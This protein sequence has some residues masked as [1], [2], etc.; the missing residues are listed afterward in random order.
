MRI[1]SFSYYDLPA[2]L[3]TCLLYLC[4]FPEDSV[5]KKDLLVWKWVAEGFV[6]KKAGMRLFEI[7]EGY[8]ND[9]INR[10]M[11]QAIASDYD[12]SIIIGCR[13]HD[14]VLDFIRSMSREE[15]FFTI[16][17]N[18][19]DTVL[20]TN[21]RRLAI[22]NSDQHNEIEMS[23]LRSFIALRCGFDT[24]N[25]LS[26]FTLIRVLALENCRTMDG[27]YVRVDHLGRLVQLRFLSLRLTKVG[28]LPKEIGALKL[29]QTLDLWGSEISELPPSGSLPVQLACLS[30]TLDG[31]NLIL[32]KEG[33]IFSDVFSVEEMSSLEELTIDVSIFGSTVRWWQVKGLGCLRE[34]RVLNIVDIT[35]NGEDERDLVQSLRHLH[36]LQSIEIRAAD[37]MVSKLP[38][39]QATDLVLP[40]HLRHLA[41]KYIY[42][43]KLPSCI[44]PWCLPILS[45]LDLCLQHLDEQDLKILGWLPGLHYLSLDLVLLSPA[46][47]HNIS[48]SGACYFP[49]LRCLN[50]KGSM[51][52]FVANNDNKGVSFF[53]W[54]GV[55]DTSMPCVSD[56]ELFHSTRT[57]VSDDELKRDDELQSPMPFVSHDDE[58]H[59][60]LERSSQLRQELATVPYYLHAFFLHVLAYVK[61]WPHKLIGQDPLPSNP[62]PSHRIVNGNG[63]DPAVMLS[64]SHAESMGSICSQGAAAAPRFMPNLQVLHLGV[65]CDYFHKVLSGLS[66]GGI[67]QTDPSWV[68]NLGWEYL[69]SLREI[70]ADLSLDISMRRGFHNILEKALRRAAEVHP[71]HPTLNLKKEC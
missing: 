32:R 35:W 40:H 65:S 9:L 24:W 49:K 54:N 38:M 18:N 31:S 55:D 5:I 62:A 6:H 3:R 14:M 64:T 51:F 12:D 28:K 4:A 42:F 16:L 52:L 70:N 48:D 41:V 27:S 44:D 30:I 20:E 17:D 7:G 71:N 15:N 37:D 1:V 56:D 45:H 57:S 69:S 43:S 47:I 2:H 11:I 8:F 19:Q 34:L 22:H 36:K 63:E 68:Y 67:K 59:I 61:R 66:L 46:T 39:W 60:P 29:L 13:V 10:S 26:S 25:P 21:V 58:L 53:I 50:L 23:K 33:R